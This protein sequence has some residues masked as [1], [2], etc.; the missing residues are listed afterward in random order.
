MTTRIHPSWTQSKSQI[1]RAS[2]QINWRINLCWIS[3]KDWSRKSKRHMEWRRFRSHRSSALT[4]RKSILMSS[5]TTNRTWRPFKIKSTSPSTDTM[6]MCAPQW[7]K[8]MT[9]NSQACP[10][11]K[12]SCGPSISKASTH[13]TLSSIPSHRFKLIKPAISIKTS[14]WIT[15]R[16]TLEITLPKSSR[17]SSSSRRSKSTRKTTI[18]LAWPTFS[19]CTTGPSNSS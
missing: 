15:R 2:T 6:L 17:L 11:W 1:L 10:S 7:F 5:M 3:A 12:Q 18:R 13:Q 4:S 14:R 8:E 9:W 19:I 16:R